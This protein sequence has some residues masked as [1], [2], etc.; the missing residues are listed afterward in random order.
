MEKIIRKKIIIIIAFLVFPL[1]VLAFQE[2]I[3]YLNP[4]PNP[5]AAY[6]EN[7]GYEFII[8]KTPEG[9]LG[10]CKFSKNKQ[11]P[12]WEFLRGED[13]QEYSYCNQA[14]YEMKVIDDPEKCG[15]TYKPGH[16]CLAC[17]L[18]DGTEVEAGNLMK[19]EKESAL[20]SDSNN[21]ICKKDG[22]CLGG[23]N[24][25]NCP[26][27]CVLPQSDFSRYF[28]YFF[29]IALILMFIIA[30]VVLVKVRADRRNFR[31]GEK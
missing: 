17:V 18:K 13:G 12:A 30:V 21:K 4:P 28:K 5:S 11:V 7:L 25:E 1:N 23:E 8:E 19:M 14:G 20:S 10:I 2:P 6:C 24:T 31:D 16:G 3:N 26:E 9:E 27:D 15:F 22:R 29:W